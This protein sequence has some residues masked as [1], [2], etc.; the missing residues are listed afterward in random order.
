[1]TLRPLDVLCWRVDKGAPLVGRMIGWAERRLG[2]QKGTA[3]YYHVAFV[4]ADVTKMY[5]SQPPRINLYP[6]PSPIPS[7]VEVRRLTTPP[8]P[9]QLK[10][11]FEYADSR[12]SRLYDFMG[13]CTAGFVEIGGL[14]FCSKYTLD[15]FAEGQIV[16][17]PTIQFPTPDDI[18]ASPLLP[19]APA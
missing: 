11:I 12:I 2:D 17:A 15:S 10:A 6:V 8:T 4:S 7:Y 19:L 18:A 13:V 3:A 5:S 14:E 1:M 16:L 9:E